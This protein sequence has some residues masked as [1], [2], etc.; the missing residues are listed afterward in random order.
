MGTF[1]RVNA[2]VA[3]AFLVNTGCILFAVATVALAAAVSY[4]RPRAFALAATPV[5][6]FY[7]L[8]YLLFWSL[9]PR[10]LTRYWHGPVNSGQAGHASGR[11]SN[12]SLQ[13]HS[14]LNGLQTVNAYLAPFLEHNPA[15]IAT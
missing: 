2:W 10:T 4:R 6:A 1:L 11:I 9:L 5:V 14:F 15:R 13:Y 12:G 3:V 7:G 8:Y